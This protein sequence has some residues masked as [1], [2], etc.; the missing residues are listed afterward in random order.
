VPDGLVLH[1]GRRSWITELVEQAK[2]HPEAKQQQDDGG[3][4]ISNPR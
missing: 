3:S 1:R 4:G 2:L